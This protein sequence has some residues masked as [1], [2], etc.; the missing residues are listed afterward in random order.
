[1]ENFCGSIIF[2]CAWLEVESEHVPGR[3]I[4]DC[5]LGNSVLD[6]LSLVV[7]AEGIGALR[8][9]RFVPSSVS[10]PT[11]PTTPAAYLPGPKHR[12]PK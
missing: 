10:L 6:L 2:D 3:I 4:C 1:M 7:D 12:V 5:C 9:L 11:L 8:F